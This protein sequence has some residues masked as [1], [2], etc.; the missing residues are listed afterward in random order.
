[1]IFA[2]RRDA[3]IKLGEE[4]FSHLERCKQDRSKSDLLVVG[5]P[6]GGVPVALEVARRLNCP[7]D[8]IAS[9]K[10]PYPGQPEYAIGAVSSDGVIVLKPDLPSEHPWPEYLE[11]QRQKLLLQTREIE[12]RFHSQAGLKSPSYA[13]KTVIIVDDGIAT[14]MTAIAAVKTARL[15]GV[16]HIILAAPVMSNDSRRKLSTYCDEVIALSLPEDF[17]AVG[18]YYLNFAQTTDEEVV[19]ALTWSAEHI[20]GTTN[21]SPN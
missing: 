16:S 17:F 20:Q 5:L 10:L 7:L 11:E 4:L 6:R 2:D 12:Q 13:G 18:R 15:R 19:A 9:K 21:Q 1:M 3:G 14:G 8:I